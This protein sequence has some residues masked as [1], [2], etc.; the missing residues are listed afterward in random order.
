MPPKGSK[1]P[2]A[3]G[4]P[5]WVKGRSGNP[6]GRPP[7]GLSFADKCRGIVSGDGHKLAWL[8][9]CL[10]GVVPVELTDARFGSSGPTFATRI[11]AFMRDATV[12]DRLYCAGRL[13]DRAFGLPKQELEHSG[14]VQ[15]PVRVVHEYQA[16]APAS[17]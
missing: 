13:E 5:K 7:I 16:L 3:V 4:N 10:C 6:L 17:S 14:A 9:G 1:N 8:Y 2:N 11:K 12:R 15:V